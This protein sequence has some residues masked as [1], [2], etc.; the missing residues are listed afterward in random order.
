MH[1]PQD[2]FIITLSLA[3]DVTDATLKASG[4]WPGTR[5]G[6]GGTATL[7]KALLASTYSFMECRMTG[8]TP[9]S[10]LLPDVFRIISHS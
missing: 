6:A 7:A 1:S 5:T 4:P 8:H 9:L 10:G 2:H 3:T